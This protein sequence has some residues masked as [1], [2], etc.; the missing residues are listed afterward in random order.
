[1]AKGGGTDTTDTANQD[2]T[3]SMQ[4]L[5]AAGG[6]LGDLLAIA[7][8]LEKKL[9]SMSES[10]S[11]TDASSSATADPTL[12]LL[13]TQIRTNLKTLM[14]KLQTATANA[15]GAN[16]A[17]ATEAATT[18]TTDNSALLTATTTA[19]TKTTDPT[20]DDVV[21]GALAAADDFMK[22][23]NNLYASNT[24]SLSFSASASSTAIAA[25]TGSDTSADTGSDGG[26]SGTSMNMAANTANTS[27]A[28]NSSDNTKST[29]PYSFASQLSAMRAQNGGTTGLPTPVEQVLLQLNRNAK[30]G[31]DQISIQLHPADLGMV[32]VKLTIAHD[33]SVSGNVIAS[34][35]DTLSMLQKD[36]RS[37]ERALQEAGLRADPGS[38]QFNL[39]GQSGN[40]QNQTAQNSSN[41]G[42][43]G[44]GNSNNAD[45]DAASLQELN[46]DSSSS[47]VISPSRVNIKV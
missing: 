42:S 38:L 21:K 14:D 5:L 35:A 29:S 46:W 18:A 6:S 25:T 41:G 8:M 26:N 11:E 47:W 30:T 2:S 45:A 10:T 40:S 20:A 23:L 13:D 19:S 16:D 44:N 7:Q 22:Q 4:D 9:G 24:S 1:M 3:S 43:A 36:S 17:A 37:L 27:A 32:D 15:T 34:N 28:T 33:G 31:N 12:A 39:G